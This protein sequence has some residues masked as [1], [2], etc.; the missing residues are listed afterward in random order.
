MLDDPN[1]LNDLTESGRPVKSRVDDP[2]QAQEIANRFLRDDMTR[3]ARRVKVQGMFDGNAQ[4]S[5]ADMVRAGRGN[6]A[7]L[8]WREHK[9]HIINAWTPYFDLREQVPVCIEGDLTFSEPGKDLM[10]MRGF[11]QEFHNMVFNHDGFDE[12][13]QLCDLQM[14]LHVH[15]S[16][17]SPQP[18]PSPASACPSG[19]DRMDVGFY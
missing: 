18:H 6:D 17:L 5:Q 11:A 1:S 12:N 13:T 16:S 8:N 14:L 4:K 7:N 10:L 2:L 15:E 9:G 3:A 19:S